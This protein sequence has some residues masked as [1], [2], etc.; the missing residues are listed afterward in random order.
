MTPS[1]DIDICL[2]LDYMAGRCDAQTQSRIDEQL[3]DPSSQASK[4]FS[5][6]HS[7]SRLALSDEMLSLTAEIV[8]TGFNTDV[9]ESEN[10]SGADL[11]D[12]ELKDESASDDDRPTSSN[13]SSEKD[14]AVTVAKGSAIGGAIGAGVA[15]VAVAGLAPAGAAVAAVAA[16]GALI[17]GFA[18]WCFSAKVDKED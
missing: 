10:P 6:L 1:H 7:I 8:R 9:S 13:I 14:V 12:Q 17:G 11:Q 15:M 5:H 16:V 2:I 3:Q 4:V 18:S